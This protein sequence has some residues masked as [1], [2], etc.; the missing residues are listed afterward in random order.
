VELE[1]VGGAELVELLVELLVREISVVAVELRVERLDVDDI[2]LEG[3]G[4]A[5]P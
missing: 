5:N 3:S 2:V 1:V 4:F